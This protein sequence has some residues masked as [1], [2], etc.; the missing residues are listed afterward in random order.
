[1]YASLNDDVP[2]FPHWMEYVNHIVSVFR[3]TDTMIRVL[4]TFLL[5]SVTAGYDQDYCFAYE[6]NPYLMYGTKTAYEFVHERTRNPDS[7]PCK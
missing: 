4:C 1:M 7:V 3:A 2:L 5:A 6:E